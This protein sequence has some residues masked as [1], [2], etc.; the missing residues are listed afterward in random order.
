MGNYIKTARNS[1]IAKTE[2]PIEVLI[3]SPIHVGENLAK[4]DL[5]CYFGES[6]I[7]LSHCFASE[8]EKVANILGCHFLDASKYEVPCEKD[9]LHL[10]CEEI[11]KLSVA[12]AAKITEIFKNQT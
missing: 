2:K 11:E 6:A 10:N 7:E 8:Y 4:S 3:V 12:F 9:S 5:S 1:L